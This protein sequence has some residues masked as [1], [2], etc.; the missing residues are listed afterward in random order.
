MK[1]LFI[2]LSIILLCACEKDDNGYANTNNTPQPSVPKD[3]YYIRYSCSTGGYPHSTVTMTYTEASGQT[4]SKMGKIVKGLSQTI[5]PV[6]Y[7][8]TAKVSASVS[9][10]RIECCKNN[11]PFM[12]KVSTNS[13][14]GLSYTINF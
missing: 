10:I 5:G 8:F 4:S 2:L 11:G 6:G 9:I 1:R 13:G 3:E 7:G 12:E 14:G